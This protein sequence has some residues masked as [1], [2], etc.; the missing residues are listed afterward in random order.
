[1]MRIS[2]LLQQAQTEAEM[3]EMLLSYIGWEPV[4]AKQR[5]LLERDLPRPFFTA[6]H[7]LPDLPHPASMRTL[8]GHEGSVDGCAISPDG[9]W[10]LPSADEA[11]QIWDVASGEELHTLSGHHDWINA[12]AISPDG[13]WVLSASDDETLKIWDVASG[14][15]LHTLSGH[16]GGVYA[17]AIS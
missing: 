14:E 4:F 2:H 13:T 7:P 10:V 9:T 5:L 11:L 17:C 8:T 3:G 15:E 12:C 6:W 1:I 16:R